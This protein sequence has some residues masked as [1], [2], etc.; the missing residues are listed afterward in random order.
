MWNIFKYQN[1]YIKQFY[2]IQFLLYLPFYCVFFFQNTN[3]ILWQKPYTLQLISSR[4]RISNSFDWRFLK[5]F[6]K[7][8]INTSVRKRKKNSYVIKDCRAHREK[9][10]PI[11]VHM[12]ILYSTK[13]VQSN[14]YIL[15]LLSSKFWIFF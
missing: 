12:I 11:W 2:I 3:D 8:N 9:A 10:L 6:N 13:E 15:L 14:L 1:L 7:Y 4:Y 5:Q